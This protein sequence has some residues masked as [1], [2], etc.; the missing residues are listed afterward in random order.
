MERERQGERRRRERN[1]GGGDPCPGLAVK[2]LM[3]GRASGYPVWQEEVDRDAPEDVLGRGQV[4]TA[5]STPAPSL[6]TF[7][8]LQKL[9]C[10]AD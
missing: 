10:V 4:Q 7:M 3:S 1:K 5:V 2:Q 8:L 9:I 6:G